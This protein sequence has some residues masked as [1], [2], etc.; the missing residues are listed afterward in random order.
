MS[1]KKI[2]KLCCGKPMQREQNH[3]NDEETTHYVCL[4][5]GGFET[6]IKGQL[7]EEYYIDARKEAGYCA[8]LSPDGDTCPNK[9]TDN[10]YCQP[11]NKLERNK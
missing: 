5:C 2:K 4:E 10:D 9:A 11:C 3:F 6:I 7:D 1:V 8:Y